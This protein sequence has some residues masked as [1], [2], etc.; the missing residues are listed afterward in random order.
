[1][2]RCSGRFPRSCQGECLLFSGLS[3]AMGEDVEGLYRVGVNSFINTYILIL[4]F[5]IK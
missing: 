3:N 5:N 1:M 2:W 4:I